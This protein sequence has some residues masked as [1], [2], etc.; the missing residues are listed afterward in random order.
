LINEEIFGKSNIDLVESMVSYE[1]M[2]IVHVMHDLISRCVKRYWTKYY[3][4][5]KV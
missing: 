2:T 5:N 4:N 1:I 3:C